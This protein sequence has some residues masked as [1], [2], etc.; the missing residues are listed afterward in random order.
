MA[1]HERIYIPQYLMAEYAECF[2]LK[3]YTL[4]QMMRI[5]AR[6]DDDDAHQL[7][8]EFDFSQPALTPRSD[9]FWAE[10]WPKHCS[11]TIQLTMKIEAIESRADMQHYTILVLKKQR[12]VE[13]TNL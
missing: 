6:I 8:L 13:H 11:A 4:P 10:R 2:K 5:N 9:C 12:L 1:V 7:H 3:L